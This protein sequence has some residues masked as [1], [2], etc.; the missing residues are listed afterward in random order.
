MLLFVSVG[1]QNTFPTYL[2]YKNVAMN[3]TFLLLFVRTR[4]RASRPDTL[5]TMEGALTLYLRFGFYEIEPYRF[6]PNTGVVYMEN[7]IT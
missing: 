7:K 1:E 4:T 3:T 2:E 5:S 6:N